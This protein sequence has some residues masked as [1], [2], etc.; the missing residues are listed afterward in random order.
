MVLTALLALLVWAGWITAG[1]G[2][3]TTLLLMTALLLGISWHFARLFGDDRRWDVLAIDTITIALSVIVVLGLLL[4]TLGLLSLH[5]LMLTLVALG[6]IFM[7]LIPLLSRRTSRLKRDETSSSPTDRLTTWSIADMRWPHAILAGLV[8]FGIAQL[9]RDRGL[10]PPVGDAIGY[11]LPFVGEWIQHGSLVMPVPAAGDPSPPFYPLNSSLWMFWTTAPFE[12]DV[13][14]RFVQ[15]PFFLLL[16][17]AV[18]RLALE[19]RIPPAGA[20]TAG[21]LTLSLPDVI[22]GLSMAEN[23]VIMAALLVAATANLALLWNHPNI[24]RASMVAALL[25]LAIGTKVLALPFA[26]VLGAAWL[27]II[28]Y[29]WQPEGSKKVLT[30]ALLGA[31]IVL[32]LGSYSYIRNTVVMENPSYPARMD[33]RG[34][35][36]FPGL[37]TASREWRMSHPFYSFD[38]SGFFGFGMR[39]FFGWTVPLLILPGLALGLSASGML[40]LHYW[41]S[42]AD[43]HWRSSGSSF[44]TTSS[45]SSTPRWPGASSWQSGAGWH[46]SHTRLAGWP[47]QPSRWHWSMSPACRSRRMSGAIRCMFSEHSPSWRSQPL[48]C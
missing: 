9:A 25:G 41:R 36:L 30:I 13:L 35:E 42:G 20:M 23:D 14:A 22:R 27:A 24:W 40:E 28:I 33:F 18:V 37:Y 45:A 39:G 29:H 38:W 19:I 32:L 48:E 47:L 6:T 31:G 15:A 3:I 26:A 16:F 7:M 8:A 5:V 46:S 21:L 2:G 34:E 4:G 17:L 12:S 44:P 10:L 11:H 1:R 43:C